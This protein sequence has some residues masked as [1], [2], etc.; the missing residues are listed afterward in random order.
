MQTSLS[1]NRA[2]IINTP[3]VDGGTITKQTA[4][5]ISLKGN[6]VGQ[7]NPDY[8]EM[9]VGEIEIEVE[10][11]EHSLLYLKIN[12]GSDWRVEQ[13]GS[14]I[15][16]NSGYWIL[17]E[18]EYSIHQNN[19]IGADE[20]FTLSI[21]V[22]DSPDAPFEDYRLP[23]EAAVMAIES[24]SA[25]VLDMSVIGSRTHSQSGLTLV[26]DETE[27]CLVLNGTN[28]N[29]TAYDAFSVPYNLVLDASKK[30]SIAIEVIS[31][32]ISSGFAAK[33]RFTGSASMQS[34]M[35]S[36]T[37]SPVLITNSPGLTS[38]TRIDIYI[39]A[40]GS[41]TNFKFRLALNEQSADIVVPLPY[42]DL[43]KHTYTIPSGITGKTAYSGVDNGERRVTVDFANKSYTGW[44]YFYDGSPTFEIGSGENDNEDTD[45]S[46]Y[47]DNGASGLSIPI[48]PNGV[49]RF[50]NADG[51]PVKS[52]ITFVMS[53][54]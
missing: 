7:E 28:P 17:D 44:Y 19:Y 26:Y 14:E 8:T 13:N 46:A 52:N 30:Y 50:I 5:S 22:A 37:A 47:L 27:N 12:T 36:D 6:L 10:N 29:A 48:E 51:A 31:G 25:N 16:S 45:I 4:S 20:E 42:N 49:I 33:L 53:K 34:I 18:G 11:P 23:I 32:T 35:L 24:R 21:M 15:S 2:R 40:S 54:V 9:N 38:F 41:A 43:F 39:P 3:T 1:R